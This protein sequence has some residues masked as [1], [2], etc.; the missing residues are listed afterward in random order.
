MFSVGVL[1]DDYLSKMVI[2]WSFYGGLTVTIIVC[3]PPPPPP[4]GDGGWGLSH[5][6][7]GLYRS[8]KGQIRILGGN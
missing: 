6:S 3:T 5:F 4:M 7:E 8:D 2:G 1:Q